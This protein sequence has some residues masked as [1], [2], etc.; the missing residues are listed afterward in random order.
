MSSPNS[1]PAVWASAKLL[2]FDFAGIEAKL[3]GWCMGDAPYMRL[4]GLGVHAYLASHVLKRP[5]DLTWP[6]DQLASYFKAIKKSEDPDVATAYNQSKRTVHGKGYGMTV[7]GLYMNNLKL[8]SSLSEAEHLNKVYE[9]IAPALPQFH[10]AVRHTAH[11]KHYLGGAGTYTYKPEARSVSGHPYQY[12]HWFWSV[13]HYERLTLSQKLWRQKR[14]MP[15]ID[16]NNISY[17]V[18][19][20]EDA[21][22]VVAFYPQSIARGVLTEASLP[23][24]DPEDPLYDRCYVGD[25]YF[26]RTPLRAPIHDSLLMEVPTRLVDYVV[27][28]VAYAM[29]RPVEALPCDP[30]WNQGTHL[31]IGVDAKIGTD[32]GHMSGLA[33]PSFVYDPEVPGD[34]PYSPAE[35]VDEEDV[36]DL[37]VTWQPNV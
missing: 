17:G 4:A 23:L 1:A 24:F 7:H 5:A 6:D 31:Q 10:T 19:L 9:D 12:Q 37:E 27:E 34:S 20:G 16:I 26:G 32:W 21:K 14:G 3:L 30:S 22:R 8:F 35:E 33:L 2:E 13:V 15:V 28:R 29:Q 11:E 18:S 36:R 25:T